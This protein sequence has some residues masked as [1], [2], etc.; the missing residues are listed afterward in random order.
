MLSSVCLPH[1]SSSYFNED[2][3][4][5]LSEE[6]AALSFKYLYM[7]FILMGDYNAYIADRLDHMRHL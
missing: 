4:K 3:W 7:G 2:T 1:Q 6:V 5:L